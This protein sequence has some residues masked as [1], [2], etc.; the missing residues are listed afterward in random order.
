M[1][2]K[3]IGLLG[4]GQLG[5]M[6][7]QAAADLDLQIYVLDPD[8][9]APCSKLCTQFTNGHFNDYQTVIDFG[10]D[11]DI[12]T[13]EIEHVNIQAL[14]Q[15]EN[16]GIKVFPQPRILEIIQ[17]KGLQ[18]NFFRDHHIPTADYLLLDRAEDVYQHVDFLPAALKLRKGGYD[19]K[20]VILL[21]QKS[22][23]DAAVQTFAGQP[24][25]LEKWVPCDKE[26]AVITAR[27]ESGDLAVY[28][29]VEAVFNPSLNLVEKL[30]SSSNL[31]DKD[32]EKACSLALELCKLLEI[33]GVLA[34]EF[35]WNGNQ[36]Y[37][38]ELAPRPHNS[39]HC[40]IETHETSQFQQFIRA[41]LNL[42]LGSTQLVRPG[43]MLN[44]LGED[45]FKG[46]VIYKGLDQVLKV[47]GVYVHLYGKKETKPFRKMGHLTVTAQTIEQAE[48][49]ADEIK[50]KIKVISK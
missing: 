28:E 46:P 23:L 36:L 2:Q 3:K 35:F 22:D 30:I 12:L 32:R 14:F 11:K 25:V 41:I 49:I 19:G 10:R 21:M 50:D 1:N 26:I 5:K 43:V 4:G 47:P 24:C 27:N 17:D 38:N 8:P 20:G 7:L 31:P 45:G 13:I 39:G 16:Q 40:T 29:P 44:I 18:K 42:P 37:V 48:K 9:Q 6:S 33:V 34:V 15:L